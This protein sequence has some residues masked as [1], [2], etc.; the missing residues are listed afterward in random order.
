[1]KTVISVLAVEV[2]RKTMLMTA[3]S[4]DFAHRKNYFIKFP[5]RGTVSS[6]KWR[7][8]PWLSLCCSFRPFSNSAKITWITSGVCTNSVSR[9]YDC[10]R[11]T[12]TWVIYKVTLLLCHAILTLS[13]W[14]DFCLKITKKTQPW[15]YPAREIS[16]TFKHLSWKG[17]NARKETEKNIEGILRL[18]SFVQRRIRRIIQPVQT[19]GI[20]LKKTESHKWNQNALRPPQTR[21]LVFVNIKISYKCYQQLILFDTTIP[22]IGELV[23]DF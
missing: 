8:L 14:P 12:N 11:H 17:L 5:K 6:Y 22:H 4:K 20:H 18:Q 13:F 3:V 15:A 23:V 1:M 16:K 21:N 19:I 2:E 7:A 9:I 10:V